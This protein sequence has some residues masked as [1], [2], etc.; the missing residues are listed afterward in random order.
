MKSIH[1][2]RITNLREVIYDKEGDKVYLMMDY[3]ISGDLAD[4][5]SKK[6]IFYVKWSLPQIA[7]FLKHAAE[8]L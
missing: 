3:C 6:Q 7:R 1:H 4:W 8:G 2:P 5:N